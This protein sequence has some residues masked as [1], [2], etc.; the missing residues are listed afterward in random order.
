VFRQT[1][2]VCYDNTTQYK[3]SLQGRIE[4]GLQMGQ[5]SRI[6]KLVMQL[7]G[8]SEMPF[9]GK[10]GLLTEDYT[11]SFRRTDEIDADDFL[12]GVEH[13]Y[14]KGKIVYTGYIQV[15]KV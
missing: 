10:D 12:V 11:Y 13:I 4:K 14:H 9:R 5:A 8:S 15:Y 2:T 1:I 6:I 7:K 3:I